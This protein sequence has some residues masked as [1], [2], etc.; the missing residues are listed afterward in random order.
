MNL[1]LSKA[2]EKLSTEF[3]IN[4]TILDSQLSSIQT[5]WIQ[6]KPNIP[7]NVKKWNLNTIIQDIQEWD[8][9]IVPNISDFIHT[10]KLNMNSKLGLYNT[11]FII[12]FK[13]K[14]NIGRSLVFFQLGIPVVADITP[15]NMHILG[16]P[17]NGYAVLSEEGWYL[18]LKELLCEKHRNYISQNAYNECKRLYDPLEWT[19]RLVDNIDKI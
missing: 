15:S 9:G 19:K 18:S 1:G 7:I 12:R 5:E 13:N 6:G 17:D 10:N 16:N 3:N 4:L 8:I 11:D 14:S 2:L